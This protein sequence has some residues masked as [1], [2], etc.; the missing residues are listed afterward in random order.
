MSGREADFAAWWARGTLIDYPLTAADGRA[1]RVIFPGRPGGPVGPDFRDAVVTIAGARVVGDIE[2]HLTAAAWRTHGHACDPRYNQVVLHVVRR[3]RSDLRTTT[4]ASGQPV[5]LVVLADLRGDLPGARSPWPCQLTPP[6]PLALPMTLSR[7]GMRRFAARVAACE[8]RLARPGARL[9]LVLVDLIGEA[10]GYGRDPRATHQAL[11]QTA[12][13][14][15][16][17]LAGSEVAANWQR[18]GSGSS[19]IRLP[20]SAF[21][22]DRISARRVTACADLLVEH[23]APGLA[24]QCCGAALAG[25]ARDGWLR[26]LRIFAPA[27]GAPRAAIVIWNAVLPCLAAYGRHCGNRALAA[28]AGAIAMAAPG[29]PSNAITRTMTRWLRL[30]RAPAGAAAQQGL[31]YLHAAWC[32]AKDCARCPLG[33]AAGVG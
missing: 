3:A 4:L 8:T 21:P 14:G 24:A 9:D 20:I 11:T 30:G 25:G 33:V 29:L 10:L 7:W 17:Q 26:L 31:H 2:L 6:D 28:Q 23:Q 18:S 27:L 1:I 22:L 15:D 32:R 12:A 13:T 5:P 16:R 19:D